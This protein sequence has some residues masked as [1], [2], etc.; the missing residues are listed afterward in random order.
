MGHQLGL[1]Q[2]LRRGQ[3]FNERSIAFVICGKAATGKR[4]AYCSGD[5]ADEAMQHRRHERPLLFGKSLRRIKEEVATDGRQPPSPRYARGHVPVRCHG[6][7]RP[8]FRRHRPG[9]IRFQLTSRQ[10][11]PGG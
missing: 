4:G 10:L 3:L 8:F 9:V 11:E 1:I 5:I 2:Q 6:S 7:D